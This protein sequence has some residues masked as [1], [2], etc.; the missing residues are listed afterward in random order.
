MAPI[1]CRREKEIQSLKWDSCQFELSNGSSILNK[2]SAPKDS[3]N[4]G[5]NDLNYI[6]WPGIDNFEDVDTLFKHSELLAYW[7]SS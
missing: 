3:L 5:D 1:P 2:H 7:L 6:D 4:Y